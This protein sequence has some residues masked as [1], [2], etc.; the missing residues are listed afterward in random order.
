MKWPS[1]ILAF[2]T[3]DFVTPYTGILVETG[4]ILEIANAMLEIFEHYDLFNPQII[5]KYVVQNYSPKKIANLIIN[6]YK[7]NI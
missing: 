1:V 6:I 3:E 5:R 2:D 4:N 7:R